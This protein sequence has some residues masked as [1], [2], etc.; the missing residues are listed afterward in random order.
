MEDWD[1][2]A[3][4]GGFRVSVFDREGGGSFRP[5]IPREHN[6]Y[7]SPSVPLTVLDSVRDL[8][9]LCDELR[10]ALADAPSW[11]LQ[12]SLTDIPVSLRHYL[13]VTQFLS[14]PFGSTDFAT[15]PI[16]IDHEV[17][18]RWGILQKAVYD[19]ELL[20]AMTG[21]HHNDLWARYLSLL[22]NRD[23]V[24]A[25]SPAMA[26]LADD[27]E[28]LRRGYA[29]MANEARKIGER[30]A[31][32]EYSWLAFS[33][34]PLETEVE[35]SDQV[36]YTISNQVAAISS[37]SAELHDV[38]QQMR[39][40]LTDFAEF[41]PE[42][43]KI[44]AQRHNHIARLS[45]ISS[46][47]SHAWDEIYTARLGERGVIRELFNRPTET[48]A[49]RSRAKYMNLSPTNPYRHGLELY[50]QL[51]R[52][53]GDWF[54]GSTHVVPLILDMPL[55]ILTKH[56]PLR[57]LKAITIDTPLSPNKRLE[58]LAS[59]TLPVAERDALAVIE[60]IHDELDGKLP[61][62]RD[63]IRGCLLAIIKGQ[64]WLSTPG[65]KAKAAESD[66]AISSD[67][68]NISFPTL[69]GA[70]DSIDYHIKSGRFYLIVWAGPTG[71]HLDRRRVRIT[72]GG[73]FQSKSRRVQA[74]TSVPN[75]ARRNA[76]AIV[77]SFP[78][79]A[80][81]VEKVSFTLEDD[82]LHLHIYP[83]R[84]GLRLSKTEIA[85]ERIEL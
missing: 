37:T 52:D 57:E 62:I 39:E 49:L 54:V 77:I 38:Y 73:E 43:R 78:Y 30:A 75:K 18:L 14:G 76:Q 80:A 13:E 33:A 51:A 17:R 63:V 84:A 41:V 20:Y 44:S 82:W 10:E 3:E 42:W 25:W 50:D 48:T 12:I 64:D 9:L 36:G 70:V 65:E 85:L 83:G 16:L 71:W 1:E 23:V 69:V 60:A 81:S 29:L 56:L 34:L 15:L 31:A 24:A 53:V 55:Q 26:P 5:W 68:L 67:A 58:Y 8:E 47:G 28:L 2:I 4:E 7:V 6:R 11:N 32:A 59:A 66:E 45:M 74:A 72:R 46:E 19:N 22:F 79:R 61:D 27:S 21:L 40:I 35:V